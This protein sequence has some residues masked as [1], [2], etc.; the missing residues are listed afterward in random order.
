M[1][2]KIIAGVAVLILTVGA[3]ARATIPPAMTGSAIRPIDEPC[4]PANATIDGPTRLI[5]LDPAQFTV[6][7]RWIPDFRTLNDI[8]FNLQRTGAVLNVWKGSEFI[9]TP[10]LPL[11]TVECV[12]ARGDTAIKIR[13][14]MIVEGITNY[15]VDVSWKPQIGGQ[16]LYMQLQT[17]F[18]ENLKQIRGVIEGVRFPVRAAS[19]Q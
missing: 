1:S 16:Y 9:F 6:P 2:V 4:N 5:S 19:N 13:T 15:R 8:D 12:V 18:P 14:T 10:V 7:A 11:N 3:C 17:R